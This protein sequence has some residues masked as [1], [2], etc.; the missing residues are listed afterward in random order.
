MYPGLKVLCKSDTTA[1]DWEECR[2]GERFEDDDPRTEFVTEDGPRRSRVV[3]I[4]NT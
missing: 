1:A 4:K 2:N 3:S